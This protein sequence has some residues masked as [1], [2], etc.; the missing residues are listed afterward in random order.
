MSTDVLTI[1]IIFST[2]IWFAVSRETVKPSKEI[3]WRKTIPLMSIGTLLT[4][5][6]TIQAFQNI[7]SLK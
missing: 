1:V 3:N 7:P 2:V 4:L 5:V 6:L